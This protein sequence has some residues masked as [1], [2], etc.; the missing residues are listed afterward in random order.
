MQLFAAPDRMKE[1]HEL[2]INGGAAYGYLKLELLDMINDKFGEARKKKQEYL[3]DPALLREI[4]AQGAQKAR[5][6]AV[7]TLDLVRE[8]V[9]LKY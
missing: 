8:R 1:I 7:V 2:Y 9:G 5:E 6:K 4:L 3:S